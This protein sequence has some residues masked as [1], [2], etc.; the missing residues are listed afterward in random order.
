MLYDS[1]QDMPLLPAAGISIMLMQELC[2]KC[3]KYNA[4]C[5]KAWEQLG[6]ILER[7]QAYKVWLPAC[8][9]NFVFASVIAKPCML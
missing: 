8:F 6:S 2:R 7:E 5:G 9:W 4:S 1:C 3:I